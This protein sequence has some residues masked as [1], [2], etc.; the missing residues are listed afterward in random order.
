MQSHLLRVLDEGGDYQRL[1]DSR[2]RRADVRLFAATNRPLA[3]L[4]HDLGAR[5]PLR[6]EMPGLNERREDVPL[7][8][9]HLL[10]RR[11]QRDLAIALRF[12]APADAGG[13]PRVGPELLRALVT[14]RYRAHVRELEAL[15]WRSSRTSRGGSLELTDAVRAEVDVPQAESTDVSADRIR[16]ALARHAE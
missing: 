8:V 6:L 1:G 9:R 10:R 13:E 11:A 5:L 16:E 7:L 14:H 15:L 3:A 2:R 12:F 4:G